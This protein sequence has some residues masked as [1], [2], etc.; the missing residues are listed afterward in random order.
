[1]KSTGTA[2]GWAARAMMVIVV[3]AIALFAVACG[4]DDTSSDS[5]SPG[6]RPLG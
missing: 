6:T 5:G 4:G 3:V 2:M 1:M